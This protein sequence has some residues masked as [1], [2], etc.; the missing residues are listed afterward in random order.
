MSV[1]STSI[2]PGSPTS[3][4]TSNASMARMKTSRASASTEGNASLRV[5]RRIVSHTLAPQM[6][7]ASSY[8]GL[9]V[10]KVAE[11]NRKT[12]G[13]QRNPSTRIMPLME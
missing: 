11:S 10:R 9:L 5:M 1:V 6:R 7:A 13:D 3:A 12:S 4:G 2:L 8:S